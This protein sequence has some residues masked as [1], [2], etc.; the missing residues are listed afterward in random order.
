MSSKDNKK[1][2]EQIIAELYAK[3]E[4]N[5]GTVRDIER[6]RELNRIQYFRPN[7]LQAE[8]IDEW[9]NPIRKIFTFTGANR[10][11]KTTLGSI[12]AISCAIGRF[13]WSG[14]S[15]AFPHSKPR[16]IR[17]I[18]QDWEY[19]IKQVVIPELYAWWPDSRPMAGGK[20]KKNTLGIEVHWTDRHTGSTIE[21]MSNFQDPKVHEGWSGDLIIYDE[22]PTRPIRTA[23]V[24]GLVDRE[25]RELFC[26]TLLSEAWI[27]QE[28]IRRKDDQGRPS[29]KIFSVN[30]PIT[31][32]V[33]FGITEEGVKQFEQ[34]LTESEVQARIH[35]K[36]L[37]RSGLV[38]QEYS[39]RFHIKDRF[40]I[41]LDWIV[42]IA[43]DIHPRERQAALF[44]ATS[45]N[46]H[47]YCAFEIWQHGSGE[48]IAE[49]IIRII[50]DKKLRVGKI[51]VDPLAKGDPNAD[52][53]LTTFDKM[54]RVFARYDYILDV[55]S[56][57]KDSGILAI[58]EGLLGPNKE[59]S[60]F[61][62]RDLIRTI[63][64]IESWMYDKDTQKPQKKDDHMME[65]LYRMML[66]DTVYYPPED[67]IDEEDYYERPTA[68]PTTGY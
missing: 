61:I 55:A 28:I 64:E 7:P 50:L 17:Y 54:E 51:V 14:Q 12:I 44:L 37:Y 20:P 52:R 16:K 4:S 63:Y 24:R 23:N 53:G 48:Q 33:G 2:T 29:D 38:L 9:S 62:F 46:N 6:Y 36:P 19:H 21:I 68:N 27:D 15:I 39:E 65:N 40:E 42:D 60:L 22:P 26:M 67:E 66:L 35:G 8:V 1:T 56:K 10:I 57:D 25:G 58:R 30:G 5:L 49:D 13:P 47:K 18:G 59:P 11:G 41:P 34:E 45:K 31:V 3:K 43:I 32:N